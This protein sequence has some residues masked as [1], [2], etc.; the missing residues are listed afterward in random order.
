MTYVLLKDI[1]NVVDAFEF[2]KKL[3]VDL[4]EQHEYVYTHW[5][6]QQQVRCPMRALLGEMQLLWMRKNKNPMDVVEFI[7]EH[8]K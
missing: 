8:K 2:V 3:Y 5:N 6:T 7:K 1:N 4:A